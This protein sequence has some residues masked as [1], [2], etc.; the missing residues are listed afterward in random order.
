METG[1]RLGIAAGM[2]IFMISLEMLIPRRTENI[3]RKHRWPINLGLATMNMLIMRI[4]IGGMAY[5]LAVYAQS[6]GLGLLNWLAVSELP[7]IILTL[8]L[9]DFAIYWQHVASH[10]FPLLWRLHQVHHSDLVF[11]ATTALRFHPLEILL[12]MLYKSVCIILIGANP[13]AVLWFEILLNAAA[14]F[15]HSNIH[16]LSC[17]ENRLR[18]LLITPDL[19]RIHHSALPAET[20]SNYGFSISL[21][22]RLFK[23]FT[24][25]AQAPQTEIVIGL[26]Q[27]RTAREVYFL[28][29]LRMPFKS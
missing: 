15:N 19:H 13:F 27:F 3:D 14:T 23:T 1:L 6:Q 9:L 10:Y 5:L 28:A 16:I 17:L 12:S 24:D 11:D 26:N 2:F 7:A 20:N 8:L 25:Q 18:W 22:D 4:S 21:W 29:L